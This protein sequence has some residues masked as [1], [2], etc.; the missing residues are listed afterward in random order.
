MAA[1]L[2]RCT[3][4]RLC[5]AFGLQDTSRLS[6]SA[7]DTGFGNPLSGAF[8]HGSFRAWTP[9]N[10][11]GGGGDVRKLLDFWFELRFQTSLPL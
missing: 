1:R 7:P 3:W 9:D 11:D 2:A 5:V 4:R 6:P 8:S 10:N